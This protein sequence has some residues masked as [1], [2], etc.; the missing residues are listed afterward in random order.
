MLTKRNIVWG[1]A[2]LVLAACST[3]PVTGRRELSL[4]SESQ[5]I[6][7]GQEGAQQVEASIGLV[8]DQALQ[9][10]VS[11]VGKRLAAKSHRSVSTMNAATVSSCHRT[12]SRPCSFIVCRD[13]LINPSALA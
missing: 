2:L 7:M 9:A 1:S 13:R 4:V 6:S 3:N 5:E 8:N 10:Y 11:S 12:L